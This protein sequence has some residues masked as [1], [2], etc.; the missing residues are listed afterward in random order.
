MGVAMNLCEECGESPWTVVLADHEGHEHRVCAQ[1]G[2]R[3]L[4]STHGVRV[5]VISPALVTLM[6]EKLRSPDGC[7]FVET[8]LRAA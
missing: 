7:A 2:A 6:T 5:K 8:V 1:C 4:K 3:I